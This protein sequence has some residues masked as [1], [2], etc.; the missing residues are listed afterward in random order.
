MPALRALLGSAALALTLNVPLAASA[1]LPNHYGPSVGSEAAKK[2]GVAALAEARKNGWTVAVAVVDTGGVLIYFERIDGTQNGSSHV[3]IEKARSSAEFKRPTKAFEDALAGP[4][5]T[6]NPGVPVGRLAVLGL[7]GAVPL[8]G[9][10][11]LIV[12]GKIIGAIGVSG[13]TSQQDGQCARAGAET[14][15]PPAK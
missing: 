13:A 4:A 12:D 9:G 6:G 10:V 2:A 5:G 8:E 7:P 3:A 1:Q 15:A 14:V 11:P